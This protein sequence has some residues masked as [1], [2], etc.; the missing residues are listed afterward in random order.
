MGVNGDFTVKIMSKILFVIIFI[1]FTCGSS[2]YYLN[3][4]S[5]PAI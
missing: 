2:E 1:S 3:F 5:E 4:W